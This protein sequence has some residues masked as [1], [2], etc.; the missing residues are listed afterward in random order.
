MRLAFL[1][2]F[3]LINFL[4]GQYDVKHYRLDLRLNPNF[5][6]IEGNV[7]I[8]FVVNQQID[9]IQVDLSNLLVVDSIVKSGKKLQFT[10]ENDKIHIFFDEYLASGKI[11]SLTIFYRGVPPSKDFGSFVQ[12]YHKG[13]P[14][15]W[16]LSEPYGAKYWWPC[17]QTLDDKADSIDVI[18]TVP[19]G[20]VV[21]S[22]GVLYKEI[23][24]DTLITFWWKH[25]YPIAAYLVAIAVTNYRKFNLY[26]KIEN[27]ILEIENYV[28]PEDYETALKKLKSVVPMIEYLSTIYGPYPFLNEKY[29]HAQFGWN[30]GMEHQTI[31]FLSDFSQ[32]LIAHELAHQWFGNYITCG[33]WKDIW[34]N[35]GFAVYSEGLLAEA[36]L[37]DI[38]W[39]SWKYENRYFATYNS[40]GSVYCEDTTNVNRL[41]DSFLTYKKGGYILHFLR[42][43]VGDS[44][45]F[46]GLRNYLSDSTIAYGF[47]TVADFKR[48]M[49][50][51]CNCNLDY[52]FEDWYYGKGYPIYTLKWWQNFDEKKIYIYIEQKQTN[53][54]VSFFEAKIPLKL[55]RVGL[56]DTLIILD[57]E[58][59]NQ[60]FIIDVDYVVNAIKFDPELWIPTRN[61]QVLYRSAL[62]GDLLKV[63][64]NPVKNELFVNMPFN[65]G[66]IVYY[67]YDTLGHLVL[68]K[69]II[70][71]AKWSIDVS[72]LLPDKYLLVV[73]TKNGIYSTYFIKN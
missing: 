52:F 9:N 55:V 11:D 6:Y 18:V 23:I 57:N 29:G 30:G 49:E 7:G 17:K 4:F 63:F 14:I 58:Y 35:E 8:T 41:F 43:Q 15:I 68:K 20:N 10:R 67:I 26:A 50:K 24:H 36:G 16:T 64:P 21:V 2:F 19:K 59:N 31:T 1:F 61:T 60:L 53:R 73:E 27:K 72:R 71:Q 33:S 12:S 13:V 66:E 44:A 22:N 39:D 25:R 48:N 51:A 34:L 45:F 47:A 70:G 37:L 5:R 38:S 54:V 62:K 28:Y 69:N 32:I 42:W 40:T 56:S 46:S 3:F 65:S